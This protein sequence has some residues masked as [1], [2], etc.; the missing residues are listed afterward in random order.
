MTIG[1]GEII[2]HTLDNGTL[3]TP[4]QTQVIQLR[5]QQGL[6]PEETA[7]VVPGWNVEQVEDLEHSALDLLANAASTDAER[8]IQCLNQE[9][10]TR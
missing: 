8:V 7:A 6:T 10:A 3:L 9:G 5:H 2:S 1:T 4:W